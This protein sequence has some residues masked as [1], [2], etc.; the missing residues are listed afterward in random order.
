MERG[1]VSLLDFSHFPVNTSP[2]SFAS[3]KSSKAL[4]WWKTDPKLSQS[5]HLDLGRCPGKDGF[6][7]IFELKHF[8]TLCVSLLALRRVT[9]VVGL[10]LPSAP[11]GG[12]GRRSGGVWSP[13]LISSH[14]VI[15][16][17]DVY[18]SGCLVYI[19][20]F[21][22]V[23]GPAKSR[24]LS[25]DRPSCDAEQMG[26][27]LLNKIHLHSLF[28]LLNGLWGPV[29]FSPPTFS[30]F[31]RA[32]WA[33]QYSRLWDSPRWGQRGCFAWCGMTG[34]QGTWL[35]FKGPCAYLLKSKPHHV[36]W[37]RALYCQTLEDL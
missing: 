16:F 21:F 6:L 36:Q 5:I 19:P 7:W 24:N 14:V 17:K 33:A 34:I 8:G 32:A 35:E 37:R 12:R 20:G 4:G 22:D 23:R 3:C 31:W 25:Q 9:P 10:S 30:H 11:R 28:C 1:I 26:W 13:Q 18:M 29:P 15:N 2:K 27:D